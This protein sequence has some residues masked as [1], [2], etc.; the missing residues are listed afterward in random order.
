VHFSKLLFNSYYYLLFINLIII[1]YLLFIIKLLIIIIIQIFIRLHSF[2][3]DFIVNGD[4]DRGQCCLLRAQHSTQCVFPAHR[5]RSLDD[6]HGG[7][8][9]Q[10][11]AI[12][13]RHQH[14]FVYEQLHQLPLVLH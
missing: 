9:G 11:F 7:N 3:S 1:L 12:L 10:G 5:L 8:T 2:Y 6:G 14:S 13:R 4:V